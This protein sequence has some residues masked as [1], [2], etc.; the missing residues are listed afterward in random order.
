MA[1]DYVYNLYDIYIVLEKLKICT[2]VYILR[3]FDLHVTD[4]GKYFVK[5]FQGI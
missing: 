3:I 1:E 2:K 5:I 4:R